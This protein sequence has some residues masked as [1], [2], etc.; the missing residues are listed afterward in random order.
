MGLVAALMVVDGTMGERKAVRKHL[1]LRYGAAVTEACLSGG[2]PTVPGVVLVG[3]SGPG[4]KLLVAATGFLVPMLRAERV[5]E[6]TGR[7]R[8]CWC[9]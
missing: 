6:I 1:A 4:G 9:A 7:R 3:A 5:L 2:S 8:S